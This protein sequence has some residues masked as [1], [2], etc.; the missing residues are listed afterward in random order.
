[1]EKD[2][3]VGFARETLAWMNTGD[4]LRSRSQACSERDERRHGACGSPAAVHATKPAGAWFNPCHRDPGNRPRVRNIT[5]GGVEDIA[6]MQA[7]KA[8]VD[9][10]IAARTS[11]SRAVA[12]VAGRLEDYRA[13]RIAAL[14]DREARI[15]AAPS[16]CLESLPSMPPVAEHVV[17]DRSAMVTPV[18]PSA[19]NTPSPGNN[20][21]VP[22]IEPPIRSG[23]D[24]N[25][26]EQGEPVAAPT[27]VDTVAHAQPRE[28]AAPIVQ[29][30]P[31]VA[32]DDATS[33]KIEALAPDAPEPRQPG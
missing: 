5:N 11:L 1:M 18:S 13:D 2:G 30:E 8:L 4:F 14:E 22:P 25:G 23:G 15:A 9:E 27:A 3:S 31:T 12:Q 20:V 33:N 10:H 19:P 17:S 28:I 26:Q 29:T 6:S 21:R 16:A 32:M 24:A 7:E